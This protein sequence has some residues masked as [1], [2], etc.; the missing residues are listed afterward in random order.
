MEDH[1][2]DVAI[3]AA[4]YPDEMTTLVGAN[5]GLASRFT[6]T[7]HFPDYTDAELVAIFESMAG[8]KR[9][10]LDDEARAR[11]AEVIAAEPRTRGFGNARFVRN[12]FE[13]AVALHAL[14]LDT[15]AAPT[16]EQLTVLDA[17][18]LRDV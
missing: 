7:I 17:D 8:A 2:D 1:R 14:R 11:L 15:V 4:G 6:R 16:Q 3:V 10:D 9:Y 12:L 18:D 5:P 13:Q